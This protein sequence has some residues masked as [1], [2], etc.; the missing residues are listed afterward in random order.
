MEAQY[1]IYVSGGVF[2]GLAGWVEESMELGPLSSSAEG[3]I[4]DASASRSN[5]R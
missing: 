1:R 4:T 3:I 2:I 5:I